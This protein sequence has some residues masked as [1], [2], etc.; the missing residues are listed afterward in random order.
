MRVKCN[1]PGFRSFRPVRIKDIGEGLLA[2]LRFRV[3]G[4]R[5]GFLVALRAREA[6]PIISVKRGFLPGFR[7]FRSFRTRDIGEGLLAVL[8]FSVSGFWRDSGCSWQPFLG[9]DSW[10][11]ELAARLPAWQRRK[12]V[13]V[14]PER[15]TM[16]WVSGIGRLP[17]LQRSTLRTGL[18]GIT[19]VDGLAVCGVFV[20][21]WRLTSFRRRLGYLRG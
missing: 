4:F 15:E 14:V 12:E 1:L 6:S 9:D 11:S 18:E 19:S 16:W 20:P 17:F 8:R 3:W 7:S 2:V 21:A 10:R 5:E 13:Q